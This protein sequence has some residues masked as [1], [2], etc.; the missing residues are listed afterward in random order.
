MMINCGTS[1]DLRLGDYRDVLADVRADL[2]LTSPPYNL[3]PA[4]RARKDGRRRLGEFDPKSFGGIRDY[5]D[6]L[7]EDEYQ[8]QQASFLVWCADH[9]TGDG[10]VCYNHKPRRRGRMIHPAEWFLRPAVRERLELMEEIVWD[11]TSTHNHDKRLM[12][13]QTER[14]YVFRRPGVRYKL[15]NTSALPQRADTWRIPLRPQRYGH[16]APFDIKLADAAI[17]A[18]SRPG[19]LVCD[20]YAGSGTTAVAALAAGRSFVGSEV[21]EGYFGRALERVGSAV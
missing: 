7:P 3:G 14:L 9:L 13:P 2:I 10:I 12:W 15:V 18:W 16:N 5:P 21:S 6:A 20:P 1:C 8:D 17:R 11:R 19:E 4:S